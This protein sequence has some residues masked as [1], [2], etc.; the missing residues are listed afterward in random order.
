MI[1]SLL[2]FGATGD[3]AG[4]LLMP[5]LAS[6]HAA[7]KLPSGFRLTATSRNEWDDDRFREHMAQ[8]LERHAP[9]IPSTSREALI[10]ATSHQPSDVGDPESLADVVRVAAGPAHSSI[11]AYLALPQGLFAPVA[12]T[13]GE[14]G[15]PPGSRLAVEKPFGEDL[16]GAIEL[17]RVLEEMAGDAGEE[18]IYRVD[19]VLGMATVHNLLG[20]RFANTALAPVW[21]SDSIEQIDILWEETLAL[22]G[23]A[24]F[25]DRAGALKDVLQ[26]HMI[27]VLCYAA[28][29][30][31]ASLRA[32][33]IQDRKVELLNA[34][35]PISRDELTTRSRRARYTA[36]TLSVNED[37]DGRAVPN[38]INEE[39]V[40]PA[41]ETET[42]A[43][44]VFA[45]DNDRWR[46]TRFVLRTGKALA[47]RH[48]E[49][50][51]HFRP[52]AS[53]LFQGATPN[54]LRIGID[55]P[56]ETTLRLNTAIDDSPAETSPITLASPPAMDELPPYANVLFDVLSGGSGRSVRGDEAEASWRVVMP[57][58]EGWAAGFVPMDDYPAGSDGPPRLEIPGES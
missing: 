20:L 26:N 58:L 55:G 28:M 15:L 52:A 25:Y 22:E 6:L 57:V 27:Q 10:A 51:V 2:L 33:D 36:G 34:V 7:S 45:V 49:V 54:V 21:N 32:S 40:D 11:A 48:K 41:R 38:Y 24:T 23:R 31:P 14:I 12:G 16:E 3:L 37:S 39:G 35:R 44:I 43:E 29:E 18:A 8:R 1:D 30:P 47:E 56:F 4:R 46:D 5:A 9:H 19:H 42:F 53:D 50:V 17:N 13:L